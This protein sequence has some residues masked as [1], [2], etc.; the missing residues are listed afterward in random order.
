MSN[1]DFTDD[2]FPGDR[3]F[4]NQGSPA[5]QTQTSIERDEVAQTFI[6]QPPVERNAISK[7]GDRID[8]AQTK[9]IAA[10]PEGGLSFR[11]YGQVIEFAKMMSE[12]GWALPPHLRKSQTGCL[13]ICTRAGWWRL[14]PYFVAEHSYMVKNRGEVRLVF[15]AAI[16][17]AVVNARAPIRH[18]LKH[19]FVGEGLDMKCI[20]WSTFVGDHEPTEHESPTLGD[21]IPKKNAEGIV[22]GSPLWVSKPRVQLAYDTM[23]DWARLYCADVLGG[24]YDK[25]ELL[26]QDAEIIAA[27]NADQPASPNLIARL[28]GRMSENGFGADNVENGVAGNDGHK[29]SSASKAAQSPSEAQGEVLPDEA[30]PTAPK[31][32]NAPTPT[33]KPATA[34]K[35]AKPEPE[36]EPKAKPKAPQSRDWDKRPPLNPREY[37]NYVAEWLVTMDAPSEIMERFKSER[38]IRNG[39][40]MVAEQTAAIKAMVEEKIEAL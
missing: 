29:A 18:R 30:T 39:V 22:K 16:F 20:V 6:D 35:K 10:G 5:P 2:D 8:P 36:P 24:I 33:E 27:Q 34:A 40:G 26:E 28:A 9:A 31:A 3:P 19:R 32:K 12:T 17:Q 1:Q 38:K 23:R 37:R 11:D 7:I 13:A 14:D 25:D 15:D 4:P 21:R